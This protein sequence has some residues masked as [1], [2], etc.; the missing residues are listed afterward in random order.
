VRILDYELMIDEESY[1]K[2]GKWNVVR[3]T[4]NVQ[5]S[6]WEYIFVKSFPNREDA[7]EYINN[8]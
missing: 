3:E 7:E 2:D 5:E 4:F 6:S 8:S 1:L